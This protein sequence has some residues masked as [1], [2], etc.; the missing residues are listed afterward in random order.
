[1]KT[2]DVNFTYGQMSILTDI[3]IQFE[4]GKVHAIIG[5]SGS[6]KTTLLSILSGITSYQ[7][8]SILYNGEDL[9]KLSLDKY[10]KETSIIFQ[11]YNLISYLSAIQNIVIALDISKTK[12]DKKEKAKQLL[13]QVGIPEKDWNRS[14]VKLSGGQQQRVA[15]ARALAIDSTIIFADEPTGNL[16]SKTGNDI[17]NLLCKMATNYNKCVICVTHDIKFRK[18]ADIVYSLQDGTIITD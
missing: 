18:K 8:G 14:C 5:S 7:E 15:I 9:S 2:K 10:R 12:E 17:T 11:N 3:N 4:R 13:E 16:D 1:L 6:G